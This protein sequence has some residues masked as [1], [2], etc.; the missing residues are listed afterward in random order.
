[1]ISEVYVPGTEFGELQMA[2]WEALFTALR[3]GDRYFYLNDP[4]LTVLQDQYGID[5]R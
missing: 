3:D 2:M 4:V 1:M 5:D